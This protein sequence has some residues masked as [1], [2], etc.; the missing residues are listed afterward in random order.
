MLPLKHWVRSGL[1]N[2]VFGAC[3]PSC[4]HVCTLVPPADRCV[5]AGSVSVSHIHTSTRPNAC[6]QDPEEGNKWAVVSGCRPWHKGRPEQPLSPC[7][8][9]RASPTAGDGERGWPGAGPRHGSSPGYQDCCGQGCG[10]GVWGPDAAAHEQL[11]KHFPLAISIGTDK[12]PLGCVFPQGSSPAARVHGLTFT[13][14]LLSLSPAPQSPAVTSSVFKP[15][16]QPSHS[17]I[18]EYL[19]S[20]LLILACCSSV[21]AYPVCNTWGVLAGSHA[22]PAG[23]G[24][25]W[26]RRQSLLCGMAQ[27]RATFDSLSRSEADG[28]MAALSGT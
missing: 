19:G 4:M 8:L 25:R 24:D 23:G 3:S 6:T 12:D 20:L 16:Q 22:V 5:C 27:F 9:S 18:S 7:A 1:E 21:P 14:S 28:V 11:F 10:A 26:G 17:P 13:L 2:E 15:S